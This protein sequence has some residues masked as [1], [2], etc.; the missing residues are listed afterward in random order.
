MRRLEPLDALGIVINDPRS[1]AVFVDRDLPDAAARAQLDP[2]AQRVRPISDIHARLRALRAARRAMAEIDALAAPV[3]VGC[4]YG[5][6]GRPPVPAEPVHR[7][8]VP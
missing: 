8:P 3:I 6:V 4:G 1:H 7:P 2:G 5:D